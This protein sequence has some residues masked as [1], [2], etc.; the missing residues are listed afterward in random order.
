MDLALVGLI[1]AV[2]AI[3]FAVI[4]PNVHRAV[5]SEEGR[6]TI[7]GWLE[8]DRWWERYHDTLRDALGWLD[9][10]ID[11]PPF[12]PNA[13]TGRR[14]VGIKS[15][16]FCITLSMMY[17]VAA[18]LMGWVAAGPN[19]LG[20]LV[21]LREFPW[22][23]AW[24]PDGL[25]WLPRLLAALLLGCLA[26]SFCWYARAVERW[27]TR[28]ET[29]LGKRFHRQEWR[30]TSAFIEAVS[31]IVSGAV[32][33]FPI[34]AGYLAASVTGVAISAEVAVI[35]IV[36]AGAAI[37]AI[38]V[39]SA[40][41]TAAIAILLVFTVTPGAE[42]LFP[43]MLF[44][45]VLPCFNG[46]LDWVSLSVSRWFGRGIIAESRS[47]RGL[48]GTVVLALADLVAALAFLFAI[49]WFL[50]FGVESLGLIVGASLELDDY[51][52]DAV[53]HPWS[54]GLWTSIMV[55]STLLPT[56]IHFVLALA[57]VWFAWFGNPVGRWC[58]AQL[59]KGTAAHYLAPEVYL[60]FGWTVPVLAVP[61]AMAWG[62]GHLFALVEPLP[63][64]IL[65]TALDGIATARA[66]FG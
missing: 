14:W 53:A 58:A 35:S 48:A 56:A 19:T 10:N 61:L 65:A 41:I 16:G 38:S 66:W 46:V 62:L 21:L 54:S 4:I 60:V 23:P 1:V 26:A 40:G 2:A 59:R 9:R 33:L 13:K 15:L 32:L 49:A 28:V 43:F 45:V 12:A 57:A 51:V 27:S 3:V 47:D 52:K 63:D 36:V 31:G 30:R 6:D 42:V 25:D 44:F 18:L 22:A 37:A 24:L 17:S 11:P 7:I 34:L 39:T 55:L 20:D 8:S 29:W 64:A 50:A 5:G